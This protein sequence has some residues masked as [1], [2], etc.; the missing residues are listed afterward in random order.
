MGKKTAKAKRTDE[1]DDNNDAPQ[2]KNAVSPA[3]S[4]AHVSIS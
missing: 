2:K 3:N 1:L 4:K